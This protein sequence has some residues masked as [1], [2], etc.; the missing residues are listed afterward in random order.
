MS[1]YPC[2]RLMGTFVE[3]NKGDS[4]DV[5]VRRT[6]DPQ[7]EHVIEIWEHDVILSDDLLF[8]Y[9]IPIDAEF[10]N[11]LIVA[12]SEAEASSYLIFLTATS[13][14]SSHEILIARHSAEIE[15]GLPT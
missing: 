7:K 1:P 15:R 8:T 4:R 10:V 5:N 11:G 9:K 3:M 13:T 6:R 14:R 2:G 12:T